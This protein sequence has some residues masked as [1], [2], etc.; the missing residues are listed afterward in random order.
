MCIAKLVLR[1]N[2]KVV[3]Q[4]REGLILTAPR[5]LYTPAGCSTIQLNSDTICPKTA[6]DF[7]D[8]RIQCYRTALAQL[9]FREQFQVQVWTCFLTSN[10]LAIK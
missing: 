6:S 8:L 7:T 3:L 1:P 2:P 4:G 9:H 10:P 5:I